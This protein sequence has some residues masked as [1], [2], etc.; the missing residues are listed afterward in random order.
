VRRKGLA[1]RRAGLGERW[2][3]RREIAA[4]RNAVAARSSKTATS[5]I[6][7]TWLA[8]KAIG[9]P[10]R[11]EGAAFRRT[12]HTLAVIEATTAFAA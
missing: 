11:R 10:A 7:K 6:T 12:L 3:A 4:R 5:G 1:G 8:A 9:V 2:L